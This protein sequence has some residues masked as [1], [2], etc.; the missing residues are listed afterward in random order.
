MVNKSLE[1]WVQFFEN[2]LLWMGTALFLSGIF[3]LFAFNWN[4]LDRFSKLG[5]VCF[6][7]LLS[8]ALTILF[9][10]KTFYFE[11]GLTVIFFLTGSALLV[12]GQI[13]QTGADVYDL[14]LGWSVLS[15]LLLP[16]SRRGVVAAL[17]MV[18]SSATVYLYTEQVSTNHSNFIIFAITSLVFGGIIIIFDWCQIDR[19][20]PKIKSF[21]SGLGLFLSLGFLLLANL[22]LFRNHK[23][24]ESGHSYL[25]YQILLPLVLYGVF[26]SY[27]RWFRFRLMNLSF[28]LLFGLSQVILKSAD[29]FQIW[30]YSSG[31]SF[32]QFG[33][34]IIG[35]TIWAV[36]HLQNLR[37]PKSIE[38]GY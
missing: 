26:Y 11:I 36:S 5:L 19:F 37:K 30:A 13:Y 8:Y 25:F 4:L 31:V 32:L 23:E 7:I 18:L 12:F 33:L 6:L 1:D 35:Y 20:S 10:K 28:I 21:L 17:W 3:F 14:F 38:E 2:S 9:R 29:I 22:N 16:V 24:I 15:L 34:F 27:Y